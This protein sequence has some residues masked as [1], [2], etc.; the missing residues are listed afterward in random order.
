MEGRVSGGKMEAGALI[1]T[2]TGTALTAV[3]VFVP[4]EVWTF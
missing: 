4:K 3:P 1:N 2:K